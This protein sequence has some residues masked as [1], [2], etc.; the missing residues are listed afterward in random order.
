METVEQTKLRILREAVQD[1]IQGVHRIKATAPA[2]R[3]GFF[4]L[5][6]WATFLIPGVTYLLAPSQGISTG[7]RSL[8]NAAGV[9]STARPLPS[10]SEQPSEDEVLR[11]TPRPLNRAVVPLAIKRVIIDP[12][13]GGKQH[14]AISDSG[15]SEKEITL[16]IALR[17][18]RLMEKS[19]FEVLLTRQSDQTLPLDKR[20]A[21]ANENR[22][23]VF[24]SIH[25]NW[26]EPREIRALETYH[27]GPSNDPAILE[28]ATTENRD[29]G[30]SMADYRRLL[31]KTYLDA[32]RHESYLL[33][34]TVNANLFQ[35]LKTA[36]PELENRGVK[37]AP[38]VV[39]LGTQMPAILVE[40][41]ALSNEE[42]VILLTNADY[43]EKIALALFNGIHA[44]AKS[45]NGAARKGS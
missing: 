35:S 15:V 31:E 7:N 9:E 20:V 5:W 14:G 37:M 11:G 29:S 32:R 44:Y 34:N 6:L 3:K 22:A 4:P 10:T 40:V 43:R 25:V 8:P 41:S 38:F 17:L 30:Y 26:M 28:L 45:L 18:R 24:V 42:D 2:Q 33:A 36:N 19:P 27:V 16:D 21:F 39:L 23:D 1:N 12:G 13:H